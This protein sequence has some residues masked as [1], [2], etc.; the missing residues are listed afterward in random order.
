LHV[1]PAPEV[2]AAALALPTG[3]PVIAITRVRY[4]ENEPL[5]VLRNYLPQELVEIEPESLTRR[6]LYQ[7]LRDAGVR[8]R[9]ADQTIGA[10]AATADEAGLLDET[11]GAALL[12]VSRTTSDYD[13]RVIEF[14]NHVYRASRYSFEL[15][16]VAE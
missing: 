9:I 1:V 16:L 8:P 4:A 11:T 6:G 14:G 15:R 13:G 2:A 3:V 7:L 12:V 10:R 5:A